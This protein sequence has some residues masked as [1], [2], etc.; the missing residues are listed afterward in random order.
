MVGACNRDAV[1]CRDAQH[2]RRG[3]RVRSDSA[4]TERMIDNER[5]AALRRMPEVAPMVYREMHAALG[6]PIGTATSERVAGSGD[7]HR[8]YSRPTACTRGRLKEGLSWPVTR[9]TLPDVAEDY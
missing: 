2:P 3:D 8:E 5:G 9:L 4:G 7:G 1:G 6:L